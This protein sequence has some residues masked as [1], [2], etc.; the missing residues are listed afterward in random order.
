[1]RS[2][3]IQ[4]LTLSFP[5]IPM[6]AKKVRVVIPESDSGVGFDLEVADWVA[7]FGSGVNEDFVFFVEERRVKDRKNYYVRMKAFFKEEGNGVYEI[8][9][10]DY[11]ENSKLKYPYHAIPNHTYTHSMTLIK[12]RVDGSSKHKLVQMDDYVFRIRSKLDNEGNVIGGLY[13]KLI[14]GFDLLPATSLPHSGVA[15]TYYLNPTWN[16]SN[17]EFDVEKNLFKDLKALEEIQ[18]P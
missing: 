17:L 8:T 7:P 15:F 5:S 1:M 9:P 13:G 16:D 14:D 11:Y 6:Y 3:K 10:L 4:D 12:H 18:E 2:P